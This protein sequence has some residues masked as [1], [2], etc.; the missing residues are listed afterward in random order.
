[1]A[2]RNHEENNNGN[3]NNDND[4]IAYFDYELK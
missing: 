1:M 2:Y 4:K 3:M